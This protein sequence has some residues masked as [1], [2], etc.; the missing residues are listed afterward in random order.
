MNFFRAAQRM[1]ALLEFS[2]WQSI[3]KHSFITKNVSALFVLVTSW[4]S[5]TAYFLFQANTFEED[6]NSAYIACT[7]TFCN[8]HIFVLLFN[9]N[10][11][12]KFVDNFEKK[13]K[14]RERSTFLIKKDHF[15]S[16]FLSTY[17]LGL[18]NET[19]KVIYD[20]TSCQFDKWSKIFSVALLN[21][22]PPAVY[23]QIYH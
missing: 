11:V 19:S 15:L 8:L 13:I 14:K 4:I 6:T 10:H 7:L 17:H 12:F 21:V 18:A 5:A 20:E 16:L 2:S 3:Q 1:F 22:T 23:C 9:M